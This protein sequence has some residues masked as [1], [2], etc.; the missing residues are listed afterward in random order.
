MLPK[1]GLCLCCVCVK[2]HQCMDTRHCT[3]QSED[4]DIRKLQESI[5]CVACVVPNEDPFI[6]AA[7]VL[8]L[9]RTPLHYAMAVEGVDRVA[10][11]LVQ[12]GARRAM[13][14]LVSIRS[15]QPVTASQAVSWSVSYPVNQL[16]QH[17]FN[18]FTCSPLS[19][20]SPPSCSSLV[21]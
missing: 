17:P 1:K 12:A 21:S 16:V 18:S 8:Q 10:K 9:E 14:D 5:F 4:E 3:F 2:T 13:R 20:P 7:C 19:S 11:V 15:T 6:C